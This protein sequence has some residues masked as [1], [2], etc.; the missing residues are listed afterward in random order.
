MPQPAPLTVAVDPGA[1]RETWCADCKAYTRIAGQ[2]VI[3]TPAGVTTVGAWS[4]CEICEDPDD[5]EV[6]RG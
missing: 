2:V 3:L 6:T 1:P 5:Q 4:W